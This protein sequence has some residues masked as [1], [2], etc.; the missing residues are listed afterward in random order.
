MDLFLPVA[1]MSVNLLLLLGLGALVGFLSGLLGVGGGF[2]LTPM[3]IM[4]GVSPVV[5]AASGTNAIVGAS[6]S[7]SLAHLRAGNVDVRMGLLMLAGGVLGGGAGTALVRSLRR[8]GNA[9]VVI[10]FAYVVLLA[11]MGAVMFVEGLAS[12]VKGEYE[13]PRESAAYR[14][15]RRL[16]LGLRF[17]A[18]GVETSALAPLL[19]G[20]LVGVLAALMGVGGGF[21]LIPAMTYLLAMPMRVA[22]GTS[23]FQMLFTSAS[24]TLMQA[25]MN[26]SVDAFLALGLLVGSALGAQLGA[27]L[28]KRLRGD[29]LKIL[30]ALLVLA[31]SL[32]M[33]NDLLV[34]P[35]HFLAGPGGP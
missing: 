26:R 2:L 16:P 8:T 33:F 25:A 12:Q 19:L 9:D 32:K 30:L 4:M 24:V 23:L 3:L 1:G 13:T 21:F 11:V 6:A 34:M 27:R 14:W 10:V 15:L 20:A 35:P 17:P 29:Q 28:A 5:S 31:L 22:V 7:G 18:S